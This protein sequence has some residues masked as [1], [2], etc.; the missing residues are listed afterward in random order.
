MSGKDPDKLNPLWTTGSDK[1]VF[2]PQQYRCHGCRSVNMTC[3]GLVSS[4]DVLMTMLKPGSHVCGNSVPEIG[5]PSA[6]AC[7]GLFSFIWFCKPKNLASAVSYC[8]SFAPPRPCWETSPLRIVIVGYLVY[9]TSP[10]LVNS[11]HPLLPSLQTGLWL[12]NLSPCPANEAKV[13]FWVFVLQP[14]C[15]GFAFPTQL[16]SSPRHGPDL[17]RNSPIGA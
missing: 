11:P 10:L 9:C 15:I 8:S 16:I 5:L 17:G 7:L 4:E 1:L 14:S 12:L 3:E 13:Q 6:R 2:L